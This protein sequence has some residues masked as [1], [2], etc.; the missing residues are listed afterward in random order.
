MG[1]G[2]G[3]HKGIYA[4]RGAALLQAAIGAGT[5]VLGGWVILDFRSLPN[6]Q[7]SFELIWVALYAVIGSA[8]IATALPL[9]AGVRWAWQVSIVLLGAHPLMPLVHVVFVYTRSFNGSLHGSECSFLLLVAALPASIILALVLREG[10][11]ALTGNPTPPRETVHR[12]GLG[13]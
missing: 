11:F 10:R 3:E 1:S 5:A 8:A 2:R 7:W 6:N 12:N 9:A 13:S 4:L